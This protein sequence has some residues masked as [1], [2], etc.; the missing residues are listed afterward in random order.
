MT[1]LPGPDGIEFWEDEPSGP[2][3]PNC[4]QEMDWEDCGLC[5]DG[6]ITNL[7]EIDPL[8]HDEDDQE[9]C[10]QCEGRGGWWLCA[11]KACKGE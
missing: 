10:E 1:F 6:Y 2:F 8:W 4:G 7:H 5:D 9:R 11:N 3:C